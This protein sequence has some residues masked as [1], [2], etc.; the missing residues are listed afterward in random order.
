MIFN[1]SYNPFQQSPLR[2]MTSETRFTQRMAMILMYGHLQR[3][4]EEAQEDRDL[5]LPTTVT[6]LRGRE[7]GNQKM[8]ISVSQR[9]KLYQFDHKPQPQQKVLPKRPR[10]YLD[11]I[12]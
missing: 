9:R 6:F 12:K 10:T 4:L 3:H 5:E 2:I 7:E 11:W 1:A 8:M